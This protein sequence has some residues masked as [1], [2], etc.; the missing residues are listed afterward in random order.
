MESGGIRRRFE[1]YAEF[2]WEIKSQI[3]RIERLEA[4]ALAPSAPS[5][6]GMPRGQGGPGDRVGRAVVLLDQLRETVRGMVQ[7]EKAERAALEAI[8]VPLTAREKSILRLHYIDGL[9]WR[10]MEDIVCLTA[11]G[12]QGTA[13]R[14]FE[15]LEKLERNG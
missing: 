9:G 5:L 12:C 6:D 4:D 8:M 3:D 1:A 10:E 2:A 7:E 13:E 14:A 11:R 15:K